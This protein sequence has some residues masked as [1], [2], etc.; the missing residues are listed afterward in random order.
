[1]PCHNITICLS[2]C[3]GSG[4]MS[5]M[6]NHETSLQRIPDNMYVNQS[7]PSVC[8]STQCAATCFHVHD[9]MKRFKKH[10]CAVDSS[11]V[12]LEWDRALQINYSVNSG[13][14]E[15]N[16]FPSSSRQRIISTWSDNLSWLW[17]RR[18]MRGEIHADFRTSART[19]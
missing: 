17:V 8:F 15:S 2:V 18:L 7:I 16:Q 19:M 9:N 4:N 6:P 14:I 13:S 11:A 10:L 1:M 12:G 5:I 3:L